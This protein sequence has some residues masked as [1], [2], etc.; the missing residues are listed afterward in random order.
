MQADVPH[1]QGRRVQRLADL[2]IPIMF[3]WMLSQATQ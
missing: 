1:T 2:E 3:G